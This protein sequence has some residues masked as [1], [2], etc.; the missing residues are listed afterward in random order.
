[1][2]PRLLIINGHSAYFAYVPM[3]TFGLCDYL[4]QKKIPA[5]IVNPAL[6]DKAQVSTVLDDHL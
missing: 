5:R 1:M 4:G 3:G 2:E 6:Y